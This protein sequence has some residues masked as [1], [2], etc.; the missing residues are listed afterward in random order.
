MSRETLHQKGENLVFRRSSVGK[1]YTC[2]E[3]VAIASHN[4]LKFFDF[5]CGMKNA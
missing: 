3:G 5:L 1:F 4:S 2:A